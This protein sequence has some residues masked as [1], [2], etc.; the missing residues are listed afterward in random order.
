[1]LPYNC[2]KPTTLKIF[3]S[4]NLVFKKTLRLFFGDAPSF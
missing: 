3:L 1:M 4:P 2:Q